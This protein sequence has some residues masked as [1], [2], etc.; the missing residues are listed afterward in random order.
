MALQTCPW[1]PN[2]PDC[3]P[4]AELVA[5]CQRNVRANADNCGCIDGYEGVGKSEFTMRLGHD[6]SLARPDPVDHYRPDRDLILTMKQWF[7]QF[8]LGAK[9]RVYQM[10][11]G[12]NLGLGM[13]SSKT[14]NKVVTRIGMQSR[15]LNAST[16]WV[17]PNKHW[18]T[19]YLR[20]HRFQWWVHIERRD[21]TRGFGTIMWKEYDWRKH[22]VRW[23]EAGEIRFPRIPK[24]HHF[25]R[26]YEARK[27]E[28]L[29]E[30]STGEDRPERRRRRKAVTDDA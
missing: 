30:T 3:D 24:E 15:M 1:D 27:F 4:Y 8:N 28:A 26:G 13:D 29:R 11:E 22:E 6:I 19:P 14:E 17:V 16:L 25:L 10:D 12:G 7:Q 9:G 18:M 21:E 5:Y 23:E 20:L 2:D